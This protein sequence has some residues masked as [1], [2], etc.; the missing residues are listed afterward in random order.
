MKALN[1][2]IIDDDPL[3]RKLT[4]RF[5]RDHKDVHIAGIA[6]TG[7]A[8]LEMVRD[9]KP[10]VVILDIQLP[11]GNPQSII[12]QVKCLSPKT[13]V[14]LCSAYSD[15][16][17]EATVK[18]VHADGFVSKTNLKDGLTLMVHAEQARSSA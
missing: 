15:E 10:N 14:Y 2:V 4:S 12:E 11:D 5:L 13:K 7:N 18:Q 3:L 9:Y 8:G 17:V 16:K 1:V 6:E